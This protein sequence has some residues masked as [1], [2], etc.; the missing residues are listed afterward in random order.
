MKS[1]EELFSLQGKSAL[2]TGGAG[3]LGKAISYTLAELGA[4]LII[5]GRDVQKAQPCVRKSC[6]S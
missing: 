5:A 2:I 1:L 4:N 6:S 3:Y